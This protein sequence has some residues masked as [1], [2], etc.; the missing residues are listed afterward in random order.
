MKINK[1]LIVSKIRINL[2][3]MLSQAK[4]SIKDAQIEA[5]YHIGAMQSRY[6]TFKEEAQYLV[7]A[8]EIRATDLEDKISKCDIILNKIM[9]GNLNS[10]KITDG[11]FFCISDL[12]NKKSFYFIVPGANGHIEYVDGIKILCVS[13][14]APIVKDYINLSQG[15]YI[16][17]DLEEVV[18]FLS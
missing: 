1:E 3:D 10:K 17:N 6:D 8:Q 5:N 14:D 4:S 2:I 13:K 11:S 15:D 16:D 18:D 9:S 12:N 7:A